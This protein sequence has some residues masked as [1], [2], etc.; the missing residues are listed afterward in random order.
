MNCRRCQGLMVTTTLEDGGGSTVCFS[1]WRCLLCGAVID[2]GINANRTGPHGPARSRGGPRY[3]VSLVYW[4]GF[5][6]KGART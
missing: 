3:G 6:G 1:G 4:G 2:S 5:N